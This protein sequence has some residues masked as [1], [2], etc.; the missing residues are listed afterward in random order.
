MANTVPSWIEHLLGIGTEA[1]EG[2]AWGIEYAWGWPPWLTLLLLVAAV[3]FVAASTWREGPRRW[4]P[5]RMMLAAIRLGLIAIVLLM[6][7]QVTLSLKRTGLPYIAVLIDDSLSM[8]IV[9][10]YADKPRK[11][12]SERLKESGAG[13]ADLSRWNLVRTLLSEDDGELLRGMAEDHKLKAYF[14][15]GVRPTRRQ[16]VAGILEEIRATAPTGESTKLGGGVR[17]ARRVARRDARRDRRV[18]RRHQYGRAVG[19]RGRRYARRRGV[20]AIFRGA[21]QR[22]AGPRS[23]AFG[24]AGR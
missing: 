18:D 9:D 10:H 6:I 23:E 8:T 5:Y 22:S 4:R 2:T 1:G 14:L 17:R 13:G 15:T 11:A 24:P 21:G 20:P 19:S 3:G 12:M 7:A 16:D